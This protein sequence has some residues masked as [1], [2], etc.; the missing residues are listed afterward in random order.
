MDSNRELGRKI[1]AL[2][3]KYDEQFAL[4]FEAIKQL[5]AED[6]KLKGAP[7]RRIG[8]HQDR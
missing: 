7:A 1:E 8:F 3:R 4:V 5:V 6:Q 2:E